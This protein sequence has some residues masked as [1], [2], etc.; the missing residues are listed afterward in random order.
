MKDLREVLLIVRYVNARLCAAACE[1][2]IRRERRALE[3]ALDV[4]HNARGELLALSA[5]QHRPI[6]AYLLRRPG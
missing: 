2:A 4:A 5:D 1:A 6:P 3:R